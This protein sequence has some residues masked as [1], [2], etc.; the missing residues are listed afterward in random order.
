MCSS[1]LIY[2][3][4]HAAKLKSFASLLQ[5]FVAKAA[6]RSRVTAAKSSPFCR[7]SLHSRAKNYAGRLRRKSGYVVLCMLF[8]C[9]DK[10]GQMASF[11]FRREKAHR[12]TSIPWEFPQDASAKI[13]LSLVQQ[14]DEGGWF[15]G[16]FFGVR[17]VALRGRDSVK[18]STRS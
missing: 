4:Y 15:G 6:Y 18:I 7:R 2:L 17:F 9:E 14:S 13:Q 8:A 5:F 16:G 12:H 1:H 3:T 11:C 10:R